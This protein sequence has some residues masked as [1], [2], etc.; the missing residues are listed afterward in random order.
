MQVPALPATLHD[1]QLP[2]QVVAQQ[3]LWAQWPDLQS[4]SAPQLAP[5]G[6]GPQLP[7]TQKL[8][9]PVQSASDEQVVLH[10]PV[11]P[12][13]YGAHDWLAGAAHVPRPSQRPA[14][15]SVLV[16][17]PALWQATP[18]TYFSQAP[19]PSHTPSVPQLVAPWSAQSLC[20]SVPTSAGMQVPTLPTE[21]QVTHVPVQ[22]LL[23]QTPSAQKL[24]AQSVAVWQACPIC[25]FG[26]VGPSTVAPESVPGW[27]TPMSFLLLPPPS[28]RIW[29]PVPPPPQLATDR[30]TIAARIDAAIEGDRS[31]RTL[32]W[33]KPMVIERAFLTKKSGGKAGVSRCQ[34]R[35][36]VITQIRKSS[37]ACSQIESTITFESVVR[38]ITLVA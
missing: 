26:V 28:G 31:A 12:H 18:A 22:A 30:A 3:T 36:E 10:C 21:E 24:D 37:Y 15:V 25:A 32:G 35:G 29:L 33:G 9:L 1:M 11:V 20:G 7:A 27:T 8:P 6:L 16:L 17:Q 38:S 2:V 19:V 23:Q 4:P 13:T 34:E 5:G 14:N